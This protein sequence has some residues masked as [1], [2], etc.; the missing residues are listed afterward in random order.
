[1]PIATHEHDGSLRPALRTVRG[2]LFER[3]ARAA[4]IVSFLSSRTPARYLG[5]TA[6]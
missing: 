2:I 6:A 3:S 4:R 1:M 5:D